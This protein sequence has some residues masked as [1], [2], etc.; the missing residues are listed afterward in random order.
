MDNLDE[1]L[2]LLERPRL[3]RNYIVSSC[4]NPEH[5][6]RSPSF[7]VF[8]DWS[9][10]RS[11]CGYKRKTSQLLEELSGIVVVPQPRLDFR[12]PWTR[13]IGD[14]SLVKVLTNARKKSP[15]D[16][17]RQRGIPDIIQKQLHLGMIERSWVTFPLFKDKK[18]QGAVA[19]A[20]DEDAPTRYIIPTGQ[21]PDLIYI[22]RKLKIWG[23]EAIYLTFGILDAISVNLAGFPCISTTTGKQLDPTSL[24]D[25]RIPIYIIPDFKEDQDAYKLANQLG[26]RGNVL[27][28]NYPKGTKDPNDIWIKNEKLLKRLIKEKLDGI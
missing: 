24:E 13:W 10:C 27:L 9:F 3:Y 26:W 28:L 1:L 18:L 15:S 5:E 20:I 7:F 17:L 6:D 14:S 21:D 23:L 12:N 4:P 8:S 11:G 22:P 16:Y 2:D 19:R 25:F